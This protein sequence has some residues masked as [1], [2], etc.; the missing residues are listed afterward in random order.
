MAMYINEK[1][2]L[3]QFNDYIVNTLSLDK[4]N[5]LESEEC[6]NKINLNKLLPGLPIIYFT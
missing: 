6:N 1:E 5:I 4:M 3:L 2:I